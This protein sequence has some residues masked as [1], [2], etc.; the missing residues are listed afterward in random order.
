[1]LLLT[2]I[3]Y[4]LLISMVLCVKLAAAYQLDKCVDKK[5][6]TPVSIFMHTIISDMVY[7][8]KYLFFSADTYKILLLSGPLYMACRAGDKPMHNYFY[9]KKKHRNINTIPPVFHYSVDPLMAV[10]LTT[11][12]VLQ[13]ISPDL[14]TRKV[15]EVFLAALPF[16]SLYK[17]VLKTFH[18]K[19]ALRPKN[20]CFSACT[21]YYGG[22]PSGHM[23]QAT[24]MAYLFGA[25]LGVNYAVPLGA[26]ATLVAVQSVAIN[27]HT[28]SQVCAG[29]ALGAVFGAAAQKVV[30]R[31]LQDESSYGILVNRSGISL[32][33]EKKF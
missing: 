29:A 14:H 18:I 33:F 9:D 13:F 3:F 24:F 2:R 19:G 25:E 26:F 23:W 21:S 32:T 31:A 10:A 20:Q 7:F 27:R 15:S 22:F 6:E 8:N 17:N 5:R 11:S 1:M 4:V 28:L 16:L 12:I 30:H